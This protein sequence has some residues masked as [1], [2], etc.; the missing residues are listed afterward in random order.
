M[1]GFYAIKTKERQFK[2]ESLHTI[3]TDALPISKWHNTTGKLLKSEKSPKISLK[4][5]SYARAVIIS[6]TSKILE[7]Y[8]TS[9]NLLTSAS[10]T[11][12]SLFFTNTSR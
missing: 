10:G 2:T 6:L 8:R 4:T 7:S 5:Y 11:L 3:L 12:Y 1:K 9:N